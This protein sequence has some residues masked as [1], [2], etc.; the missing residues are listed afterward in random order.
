MRNV[1]HH[2][3]RRLSNVKQLV[4]E[5]KGQRKHKTNRPTSDSRARSIDLVSVVDNGSDF[6]VGT[7]GRNK[8]SLELHLADEMFVLRELVLLVIDIIL[9][10]EQVLIVKE[11][12]DL[13]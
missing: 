10:N 6:G 1:G 9:G 2:T 11:S 3:D 7:V 8:R 13:L 4:N 12:P 5:S